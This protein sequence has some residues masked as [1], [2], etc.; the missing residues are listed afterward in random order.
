V[1]YELLEQ[2]AHCIQKTWPNA[3]PSTALICGSGWSTVVEA[4]ELHGSLSYEDIPG[5]GKPGVV[6]HA[7]E[8]SWGTLHGVETFIFQGRR[9]YYEGVGW[10]PIALPIYVA[11]QCGVQTMVL[12]NSAGCMREDLSPGDLLIVRDHFNFMGANPLVGDHNPCWGPRFPDQSYVYDAALREKLVAAGTDIGLSLSQGVYLAASGP[13]YE[14]PFEIQAFKQW[15]ADAVGM[16][17]VPE[18]ILASAAGLR[19]A[20]VSCMTNYAAGIGG[21][22]LS[23][24]EVTDTTKA[25]MPRMKGLLEQFWK[26]LP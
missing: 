16:S 14:S 20:C 5:F 2:A 15:G 7:G 13:T 25:T 19:V 8:L 11:K 12:T 26:R 6:G 18:A 17:T 23:H 1:N 22:A 24:E 21:Q 4:F 10:T 3:R 9:H